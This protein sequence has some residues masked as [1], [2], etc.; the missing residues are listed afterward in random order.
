MSLSLESARKAALRA[1]EAASAELR[2]A[3]KQPLSIAEKSSFRDIVTNADLAS[4]KAIRSL[5]EPAFPGV[6]WLG[7]ESGNSL[8][9]EGYFWAVDPLDGT[10]NF[11]H[12]YPWFAVSIALC[13]AAQNDAGFIPLMGVVQH[14]LTGKVLH[15]LAG[16]GAFCGPQ[17]LAASSKRSLRDALVVTGFEYNVG[18]R[19][20]G[21]LSLIQEVLRAVQGMRRSGSAVLDLAGVAEGNVDAFFEYGNKTW[22]VAAGLLLVREAGGVARYW[23]A[24]RPL[25]LAAA[26]GVAAELSGLLSAHEKRLALATGQAP[27]R[28]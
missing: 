6:H 23:H 15:A 10:T 18:E 11:S 7:E 1:A 24:E 2:A 14:P 12:G 22:D 25:T 5:L 16:K 13:E 3:M 21:F 4:E 9:E 27:V 26:P 8:P 28:H 17:R 20:Q 19:L